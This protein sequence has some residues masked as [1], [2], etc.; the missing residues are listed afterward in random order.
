[1][2]ERIQIQNSELFKNML[3]KMKLFCKNIRIFHSVYLNVIRYLYFLNKI[4]YNSN[5]SLNCWPY[6][7]P[8]IMPI[9]NANINMRNSG[10]NCT[11]R[12]IIACKG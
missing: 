11:N 3:T 5:F 4:A 2:N 10:I 1:M 8:E 7:M 6:L 12:S 9:I